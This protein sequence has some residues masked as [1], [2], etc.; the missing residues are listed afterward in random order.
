MQFIRR[1]SVEIRTTQEEATEGAN[2][3]AAFILQ[4][5]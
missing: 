2:E 3:L 5:R 4:L 1:C